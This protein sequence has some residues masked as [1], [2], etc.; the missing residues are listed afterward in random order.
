MSNK[1]NKGDIVRIKDCRDARAL[2]GMLVEVLAPS[3]TKNTVVDVTAAAVLSKGEI[4]WSH[5]FCRKAWYVDNEFLELVQ[6]AIKVETIHVET[7][8]GGEAAPKKAA[9]RAV[10]LD[11]KGQPILAPQTRKVLELLKE[12]GSVTSL[13]AQGVLR[14]RSLS[15]RILDLKEAGYKVTSTLSRDM[16]GQRYARYYLV[17]Q[18]A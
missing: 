4:G 2:R 13:E 6:P 5:S 17:G 9:K 10:K 7:H 16:T 3:G 8:I 11:E 1:F 15:R 14:A 12:K 18:A